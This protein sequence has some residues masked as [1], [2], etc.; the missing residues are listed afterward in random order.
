MATRPKLNL[1]LDII[2]IFILNALLHRPSLRSTIY[3]QPPPIT[4]QI[5]SRK[6]QNI[7]QYCNQIIILITQHYMSPMSVHGRCQQTIHYISSHIKTLPIHDQQHTHYDIT[8]V[9]TTDTSSTIYESLLNDMISYY[10]LPIT[11]HESLTSPNCTIYIHMYLIIIQI[12][13][14][15]IR[16]VLTY[17]LT[18]DNLTSF[19]AFHI[20]LAD[21]LYPLH[22]R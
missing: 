2:F 4:S 7:T 8:N 6:N 22:I 17:N 1:F 19:L 18:I 3:Y 14:D 11:S 12:I 21:Y 20:T 10:P 5:K 15:Y 9:S 13:N 16:F